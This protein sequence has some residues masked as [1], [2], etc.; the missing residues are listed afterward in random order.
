M[1]FFSDVK[2]IIKAIPWKREISGSKITK[3]N[4]KIYIVLIIGFKI[5]KDIFIILIQN[6]KHPLVT[7]IQISFK[8][9]LLFFKRNKIKINQETWIKKEIRERKVS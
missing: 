8:K 6:N 4:I 1:F 3:H 7:L 5:P 2:I 9:N